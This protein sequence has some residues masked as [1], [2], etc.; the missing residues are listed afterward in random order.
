MIISSFYV[1]SR[2]SSCQTLIVGA[3][4]CLKCACQYFVL[5]GK[6][7]TAQLKCDV[8]VRKFSLSSSSQRCMSLDVTRVS[9]Q[10]PLPGSAEFKLWAW[11][12]WWFGVF[13]DRAIKGVLWPLGLAGNQR[14]ASGPPHPTPWLVTREMLQDHPTPPSF[15]SHPSLLPFLLW[16]TMKLNFGTQFS[17]PPTSPL[18]THTQST[19]C[20]GQYWVIQCPCLHMHPGGHL[21]KEE[22]QL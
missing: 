21:T 2:D 4:T 6:C 17:L 18:V 16:D 5:H 12:R 3:F 19:C 10:W 14:D 22:I 15:Q 13:F 1:G 11:Q 9:S 7:H 8:Q 20:T